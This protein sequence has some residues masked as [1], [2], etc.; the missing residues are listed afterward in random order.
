MFKRLLLSILLVLTLIITVPLIYIYQLDTEELKKSLSTL[1]SSKTHHHIHFKGDMQWRVLPSIELVVN[2]VTITPED[3]QSNL[4]GHVGQLAFKLD[5][6]G[7]IHR[8]LNFKKIQ[9]NHA[10]LEVRLS[11]SS[12]H[13]ASSP[14]TNKHKQSEKKGLSFALDK[15]SVQES[16]FTLKTE[17]SQL[18][19]T[20][21]SFNLKH[22]DQLQIFRLHS[23]VL[24]NQKKH[25]FAAK[26]IQLSGT[27][28]H[29]DK[30]LNNTNSLTNLTMDAN[31]EGKKVTIDQLTIANMKAKLALNN[32][33]IHVNKYQ[34]A[35]ADGKIIGQL[36]Y[37]INHEVLTIKQQLKHINTKE[38]LDLIKNHENF[39]GG[40]LNL[41]WQ[42]KTH[43]INQDFLYHTQGSGRL[44]YDNTLINLPKTL[45]TIEA[46]VHNLPKLVGQKPSYLQEKYKIYLQ[47][48]SN[49]Y[50]QQLHQGS[51]TAQFKIGQGI[52]NLS[53]VKI[54]HPKLTATGKLT[55]NLKNQNVLGNMKLVTNSIDKNI[56]KAQTMLHGAFPLI[57]KGQLS[58]L[59][60][61]PNM[62][63][64][65]PLLVNQ[66]MEQKGKEVIQQLGNKLL[67]KAFT[68]LHD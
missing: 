32:G 51:L 14:N 67:D 40:E 9:L 18:S 54:T 53:N 49:K 46:L 34:L 39:M 4:Q 2:D 44:T 12:Q 57:I 61:Y 47:P 65:A 45:E 56:Q 27:I 63:I 20:N 55:L 28:D 64:I 26:D 66:F 43:P 25:N 8:K 30:L 19:L 24:V 35:V 62:T 13:K 29:L 15:I 58:D 50:Y 59:K 11:K 36:N 17:Q 1:L 42:S 7:L 23:N 37:D 52:V 10:N 41:N 38:L 3:K 31:L 48:G 6:W 22:R 60:V 5:T 16:T 21:L 33:V 68:K